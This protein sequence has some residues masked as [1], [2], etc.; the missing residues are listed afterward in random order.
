MSQPKKEKGCRIQFSKDMEN[1]L[2]PGFSG[3]TTIKSFHK[4]TDGPPMTSNGLTL[5][6][7][8]A[9]VSTNP[10]DG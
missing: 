5:K 10:K 2:L 7:S 6:K 3:N 1:I 8:G 9:E 4:K